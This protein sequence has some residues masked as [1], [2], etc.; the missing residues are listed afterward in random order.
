MEKLLKITLVLILIIFTSFVIKAESDNGMWKIHT[1][2]ND[3]RTRVVDTGDRVYCVTENSLNVYNKE[4]EKF[5]SLSKLNRLSGYYVKNIY[6]NYDKKYIVVTYTDFNID[7]LRSDGTTVNISNFKSIAGT[8]DCTINDVT[9]GKNCFYVASKVG[10]LKVED[11]D[12]TVEKAAF[13]NL[14]VQS[15]TEVGENIILCNGS[16]TFYVSK[17]VN[18]KNMSQMT[19]TS[20]GVSGTLLPIDDTHFFLNGSLLYLVTISEDGSFT[21]TAV[22]SAKVYD[23]QVAYNGFIALGGTSATVISK[24]YAFDKN[25]NKTADVT[26]PEELKNTLL[27]SYEKDGSLWK[28]GANGLQN[29]SLNI[30]DL[31]M[32]AIGDEIIPNSVTAKRIGE[33]AYNDKNKKLYVTSGGA[34]SEYLIEMYGKTAYISSYDG[35][36]WKNEIPTDLK[37][38]KF[39]DPYQP[40][41]DRTDP[42]TFYVGT[43]YQG[44]FKIKNNEIIAKYDWTNSPLVHAL[45]NWFCHVPCMDFDSFGNLW[46]IQHTADNNNKEITILKNSS[47]NK[48]DN[49]SLEDWIVP[50]ITTKHQKRLCFH[51]DKNDNKILFDGGYDGS[52]K[53]FKNDELFQNIESREFTYFYDQDGKKVTWG[54]IFDIEEDKNGI[55]WFASTWGLFSMNAENAFNEDFSIIK[56]KD[57]H[58]NYILDNVFVTCISTDEYNRK[59]VGTLDD[60]I[61]LLNED[62]SK[63]LK[64]FNSS[65]SI[66]P[67]DKV[68]SICW[69]SN[70]KSVFVGLNGCLLEYIPENYDDISKIS[71]NPNHIT[72][73]YKGFV[74]FDNIPINSILYIKNSNGEIVKNIQ[75]TSSKVYWNCTNN[76]NIPVE[77]GNYT[78]SVKLNNQ[79][80]ENDNILH[81][82]VI[83]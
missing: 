30:T 11:T 43:W 82:S 34:K 39:Q 57:K 10:Y 26:L 80:E 46:T 12:F 54:L 1:I 63:V 36:T 5:E 19:T 74:I 9:F 31:T 33:L 73:D 75:A 23:V 64:H 59:W 68:F 72:P 48:V 20:L 44:I 38:Y 21:K 62:C 52:I 55:L 47:V 25:G 4:T 65:N 17:D 27:S 3:N 60:G 7:I 56:P 24:Y 81:F 78:L 70:T 45:N 71:V 22:S 76:D 2:F 66:F 42:N 35:V 37:G 40:I 61:Y 8:I 58:N 16:Q 29:V 13:F 79:I 14:N 69:N 28:L 15:V 67:N 32:T 53:I 41:F 77:T 83:K 50:E 18:V 6:Y 51:I 49:I